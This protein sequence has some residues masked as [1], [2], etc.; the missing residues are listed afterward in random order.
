MPQVAGRVPDARGVSPEIMYP[1]HD[2]LKALSQSVPGSRI[3]AV[4][5]GYVKITTAGEYTF[6]TISD[7][8]SHL[9]VDG[10]MIV[11]NG[12]LHAPRERKGK[13]SLSTGY[14]RIKADFFENQGGEHMEVK[15]SGP[16]TNNEVVP[17]KGVHGQVAGVPTPAGIVHGFDSWFYYIKRRLNRMP[18]VTGRLPDF[19][20]VSDTIE[21]PNH[22]ALNR[23][24]P[25]I[26]ASRIAVVWK[27]YIKI[28]QAGEY[29]F[30]TSSD[31][32]SHLWIGKEMIVD[33]S[34]LHGNRERKGEIGLSSGYHVFKADFFENGG[35]E[36]MVVKYSG[37]DTDGNWV[38]LK[39]FH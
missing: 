11:R 35:G 30:S 39:G 14:H 20:A 10:D 26:P 28:D 17:L 23:A 24:A 3:A 19:R 31:D 12:G 1:T 34:G 18:A 2:S 27:G 4:W 37:P 6:A 38:P 32:G 8:G 29:A 22:A 15:Y 36:S 16:D 5:T 7:D 25:G 21:F 13:M 9:W 33:N